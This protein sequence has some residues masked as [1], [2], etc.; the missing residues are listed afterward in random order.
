MLVDSNN[1]VRLFDYLTGEMR[2]RT[3]TITAEYGTPIWFDAAA[4][5]AVAVAPDYSARLFNLE[6]GAS[7][8]LV[9]APTNSANLAHFS[10]G[11]FFP[12]NRRVA[13]SDSDRT[14]RVFDCEAGTL[15][16]P[17][18]TASQ[19]VAWLLISPDGRVIV[20]Q[21]NDV[22]QFWDADSG[23]ELPAREEVGVYFRSGVFRPNTSQFY[24]AGNAS[25]LVIFEPLTGKLSKMPA[26]ERLL[27]GQCYPDPSGHRVAVSFQRFVGVYDA[28]GHPLCEPIPVIHSL[29]SPPLFVDEFF[30]TVDRAARITL[31]EVK[32][33]RFQPIVVRHDAAVQY[34]SFSKSGERFVTASHDGTARLWD[35]RNGQLIGAPMVHKDQVWSACFS[36]DGRRVATGSWDATARLWD[37]ETGSP[38]TASLR[39]NH[40]VFHVEFSPDGS[41]V[42]A[43]G[44]DRTA[45]IYD[46]NTGKLLLELAEKGPVYWAHFSPDGRTIATRPLNANPKLWDAQTGALI[47]ELE[48]P[49][50]RH[51]SGGIVSRGDFSR[52]G[53]WFAVGS[54]N[55]YATVWHLPDG[56]LHAVLN[57]AAVV[58]T[59]S[60]SPD[61]R[62][63]LTTADDLTG[64]LWDLR[65]GK[66]IGSP[67]AGQRGP[68]A[69]PN[70]GNAL[71]AGVI[72]PDGRRALTGG[73]DAAA[74][75]WNLQNGLPLGEPAE[76]EGSV[77]HAEFSPDGKRVLL[78]CFDGTAHIV[79]LPPIVERAPEWL[80]P[81]AEALVGQRFDARGATEIVPPTSL[82]EICEE[83]RRAPDAD[84]TIA[85]VRQI[86][87]L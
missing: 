41:K 4:R 58:R 42:L 35:A 50:P 56:K 38:L 62:T 75:L 1:D 11:R 82:W 30:A 15:T 48:E 24:L 84:G 51:T 34:T 9:P 60:F 26:H 12:D 19:R 5:R 25:G 61:S 46:A 32:T 49:P 86:L 63:I 29:A 65:T 73:S 39:A 17:T 22:L 78:A 80:G 6:T 20:T 7:K 67:L 85:W 47:Q 21:S 40:F 8:T 76:F 37:A 52:D 3:V 87:D 55:R 83:I 2:P 79:L 64:Q 57:H 68:G 16:G 33:N 31:W 43:C 70:T 54:A 74:R 45:R 69:R 13:F 28:D 81:L 44:E 27:E 72:H 53:Q 59:A 77:M 10:I 66:A 23:R 71:R 14:V 18:L 36:P